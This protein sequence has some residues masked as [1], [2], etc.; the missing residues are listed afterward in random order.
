[1]KPLQHSHKGLDCEVWTY[2]NMVDKEYHNL[3]KGFD[4]TNKNDEKDDCSEHFQN[5]CVKGGKRGVSTVPL[6]ST[7][8]L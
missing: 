6:E 8:I 7:M 1:M 4:N 5:L 2:L 3:F